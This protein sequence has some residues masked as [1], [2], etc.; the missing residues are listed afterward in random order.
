MPLSDLDSQM[1]ARALRLAERG[2]YTT[3]PNPRVGCVIALKGEPIAEGWHRRAGEAHAE[4]NALADAGARAQ[5]ATAYVTLEPCNHTGRTGPCSQALIDAGITR[6]VFGMEDPNPK[7]AGEGLERLRAAGVEVDG[8]LLEEEIRALNPGFIKRMERGLPWVRCKLA[9]SLD[10]RT[11]MASG[12]SKWVTGRRARED[13]QRLRARSCVIIS[14]IDTVLIDQA[15]LTV[16]ADELK[17]DDAAAIAER[18][19][20]RVVLDS[21]GRMTPDAPLLQHPGPVL[22]V[23]GG[24][25]A[26][27]GWPAQVETL[28]LAGRDG[29]ID[30]TALLRELARREYNEVLV[31]SGATLAGA[32]LGQGLLD[33]MIVYMAPKLLGSNARP[34]FQLPLDSMAA[35][36][37]LKIHDIRA[38]G[39]D[40]RITASPDPE[41]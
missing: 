11:A 30:L 28:E 9:M 14:G 36:L 19:P 10:G 40:W 34:L 39:H 6:V 18:Q 8:P 16:R 4:V 15:A 12:E 27:T 7:V 31:E 33:E 35:Q 22:L 3:T 38:V 41:G 1:M 24:D 29:R 2:L 17:L 13:V 23:H 25:V 26:D 32:F 21:R 20:L 5:G 37:P